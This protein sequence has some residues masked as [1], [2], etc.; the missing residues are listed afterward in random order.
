MFQEVV[1]YK[2]K[3]IKKP[4]DVFFSIILKEI[5]PSEVARHFLH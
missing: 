3:E 5:R 4:L 1:V 2:E